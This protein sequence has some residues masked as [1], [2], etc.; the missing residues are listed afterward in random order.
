MSFLQAV[1]F[2]WVNP[3]AWA[4]AVSAVSAYTP[5]AGY[6]V[7]LAI[8]GLVFWAV[9]LPCIGA[10]TGFGVGMRRFL[11]RPAALRAFNLTMAGLLVLSLWPMLSHA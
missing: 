10:W 8:M 5:Q 3:K 9:N 4:M 6:L 11:D 7:N 1:G 2:Q